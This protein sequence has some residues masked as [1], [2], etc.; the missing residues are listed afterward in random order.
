MRFLS[1]PPPKMQFAAIRPSVFRA[2]LGG[3]DA[4]LLLGIFVASQA[5]QTIQIAILGRD[6]RRSLR[7]PPLTASP[8]RTRPLELDDRDRRG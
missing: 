4:E 7:P 3:M 1:M 5:L 8:P 6:V 2:I